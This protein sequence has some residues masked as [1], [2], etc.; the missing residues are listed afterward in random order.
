[1]GRHIIGYEVQKILAVV[2]WF[3]QRL[4]RESARSEWPAT[5]R[6]DCSRFLC[7]RGRSAYRRLPGERLLRFAP[8]HLEGADL[9][10][11]LGLA[12][13]VRRRR[14]RHAD[15]PARA[16]RGTQRGPGRDGPPAVRPGRRGGAARERFDTPDFSSVQAEFRRIDT[17]LPDRL[18]RR[19][20]IA[21]KDG[22]TN[23]P[24]DLVR[25]CK[26]FAALLGVESAMRRSDELPVPIDASISIPPTASS[27]RSRSWSVTCRRLVRGADRTRERFFL[28]D[29]APVR[30]ASMPFTRRTA[31]LPRLPVDGSARQVRRPAAAAESAVAEDLR[32][33]KVDRLRRGAG[34]VSRTS[35]P[36]AC[37][38][39]RRT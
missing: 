8:A 1:M 17:L 25:R 15:C 31:P 12:A 19:R 29:N 18:Q 30:S 37:C 34:C 20:L 5:V 23:R 16:G 7:R 4:G 24:Q 39:C 3:K 36:G 21:G 22:N 10:Q 33:R 11:C 27:G 13:R 14:D 2:D 32:P 6:A 28:A 38:C 26:Q 9:P 35:S